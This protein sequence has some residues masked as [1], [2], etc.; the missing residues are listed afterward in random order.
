[1]DLTALPHVPIAAAMKQ[2]LWF[3]LLTMFHVSRWRAAVLSD[4][5]RVDAAGGCTGFALI[6]VVFFGQEQQDYGELW[7][8]DLRL[9]SFCFSVCL[10]L[11]VS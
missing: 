8:S 9:I 1:M 2:K 6:S 7:N 5:R 11:M 3:R 10:Y 4:E